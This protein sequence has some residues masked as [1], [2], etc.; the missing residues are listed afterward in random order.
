MVSDPDQWLAMRRL[1]NSVV[2]EYVDDPEVL[3]AAPE[4]AEV[5]AAELFKRFSRIRNHAG[6]NLLLG[7]LPQ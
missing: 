1:R 5:R 6:K 4:K 7:D 3:A 2:H